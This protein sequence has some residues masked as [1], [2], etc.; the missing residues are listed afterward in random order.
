VETQIGEKE[1]ERGDKARRGEKG[2]RLRVESERN[3]GA[4]PHFET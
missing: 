2:E 1:R 4:A 3:N